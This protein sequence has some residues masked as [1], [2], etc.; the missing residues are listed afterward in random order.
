MPADFLVVDTDDPLNVCL[1]ISPCGFTDDYSSGG[2]RRLELGDVR[3]GKASRSSHRCE[4]RESTFGV[5]VL[6]PLCRT[7]ERR[8][9]LDQD[10]YSSLADASAKPQSDYVRRLRIS[11][12]TIVVS[13]DVCFSGCPWMGHE[14]NES[15]PSSSSVLC[16]YF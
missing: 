12:S 4:L 14:Q 9:P 6:L 11:R 8:I 16:K 1:M 10:S 13:E 5:P 15:Q 3:A 2:R 7:A